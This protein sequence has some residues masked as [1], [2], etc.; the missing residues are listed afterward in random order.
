MSRA[1]WL[2][3]YHRDAFTDLS[4]VLG[5]VACARFGLPLI[6]LGAWCVAHRNMGL[7]LDNLVT[8]T[9]ADTFTCAILGRVCLEGRW[10][11]EIA[12]CK[13]EQAGSRLR[14]GHVEVLLDTIET[15]KEKAHSQD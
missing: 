3:R 13:G 15:P 12:D 5:R 10:I 2:L 4:D 11:D 7:K 8:L 6:T 14:N 1:C 9:W